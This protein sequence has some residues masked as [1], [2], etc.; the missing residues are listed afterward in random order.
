MMAIMI[1]KGMD[2]NI[3][4]AIS[5]SLTA[6]LRAKRF[7]PTGGVMAPISRL[8]ISMTPNQMGS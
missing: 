7:T 4:S 3:A 2:P 8:R 5:I 6:A 1:I